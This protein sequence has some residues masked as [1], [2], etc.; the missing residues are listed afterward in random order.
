MESIAQCGI[1]GEARMTCAKAVRQRPNNIFNNYVYD[2]T[3]IVAAGVL[4]FFYFLEKLSDRNHLLK[5]KWHT[6][7]DRQT[8]WAVQCVHIFVWCAALE[9]SWNAWKIIARMNFVR[10]CASSSL[11]ILTLALLFA[12]VDRTR[13]CPKSCADVR[14]RKPIPLRAVNISW[15]CGDLDGKSRQPAHLARN[16]MK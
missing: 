5:H 14:K 10:T 3:G 16:S 6:R 8:L 7:G 1:T 13:M 2:F 12:E 11:M 9:W 4:F 15:Q